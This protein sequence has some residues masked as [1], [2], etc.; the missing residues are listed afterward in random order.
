MPAPS[1]PADLGAVAWVARSFQDYRV[2]VFRELDR[3]VGGR[4]HLFFSAEY[5][6]E[7]LSG[8]AEKILGERAVGLTGEWK[9][10]RED[11][12]FLANRNL[13]LRLQP[14]LTR[15]IAAVRP[16]VVI[17]EGFFKW[18]F[19]AL[20]F[21]RGT[22]TPLVVN[23]ERTAHTERRVQWFRTRYRRWA[24]DR[25][26][27]VNCSGRLCRDY[28]ESLGFDPARIRTGHMVADSEDLASR[29]REQIGRAH[30]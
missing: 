29:V 22:G 9:L 8:K 11:K 2:P 4:L 26:A 28:V 10:G 20:R 18:T 25:V 21:C 7:P 30:V 24:L 13:S 17:G 1:E 16:S 27:A 23:Y 5:V 19:Q 6:G 3:L 15:A 12:D 14:G